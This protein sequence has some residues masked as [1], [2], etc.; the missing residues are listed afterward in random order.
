MLIDENTEDSEIT[1][2]TE[3]L[4]EFLIKSS[5]EANIYEAPDLMPGPMGGDKAKAKKKVMKIPLS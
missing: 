5:N 3:L 1:N 2:K 4:I